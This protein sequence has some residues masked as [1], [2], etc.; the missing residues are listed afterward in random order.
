LGFG[1]G[2]HGCLGQQVAR[3]EIKEGI[4][5]L[6]QAFPNLKLVHAEQE[7]PMPFYHPVAAYQV[8]EVIIAWE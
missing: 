2:L 3:I 6:L 4:M 7:E 5:Q 8:G 1:N